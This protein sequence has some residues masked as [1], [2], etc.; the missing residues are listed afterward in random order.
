VPLTQAD[1]LGRLA[2][3][4]KHPERATAFRGIYSGDVWGGGSGPG[5]NFASTAEARCTMEALYEVRALRSV[6]DVCG[7]FQWM[8][9]WLE[10]H[11][12]VRYEGADVVPELTARLQKRFGRLGVADGLRPRASWNFVA[13]D[14][15][16]GE[17]GVLPGPRGF[18]VVV[19]R[20]V[21]Q[22]QTP[23]E[24]LEALRC[25][26]SSGAR[27]LLATN[28]PGW[29]L[30]RGEHSWRLRN[31]NLDAAAGL[32]RLDDWRWH[33]YDLTDPPYSLPPPLWAFPDDGKVLGLWRLPLEHLR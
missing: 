13:T 15:V 21:L 26:S 11:P 30:V 22:H 10:R 1:V 14:I 19:L 33:A 4:I 5:S 18:D 3:V 7:D 2:H 9:A 23:G 12:A 20:E 29:Q 31:R 6:W 24:M 16:C 27:W 25:V 17:G 28:F 8:R 32:E